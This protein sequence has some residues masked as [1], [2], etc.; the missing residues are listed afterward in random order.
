MGLFSSYFYYHADQALTTVGVTGTNGK[1]TVTAYVRSLLNGVGM[2]TESIGTAG[3]WDHEKELNFTHT[4][5]TTPEA[6]DT[7]MKLFLTLFKKG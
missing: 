6:P 2:R 3:I 7:F 5:H 4:T 1:T